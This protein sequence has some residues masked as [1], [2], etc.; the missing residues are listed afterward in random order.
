MPV[1]NFVTPTKP[2]LNAVL[3]KPWALH[4][5]CSNCKK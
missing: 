2:M 1:K 3:D 4:A 5:S